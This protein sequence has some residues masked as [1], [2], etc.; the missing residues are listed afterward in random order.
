MSLLNRNN[1]PAEQLHNSVNLNEPEG[2][3]QSMVS[4]DATLLPSAKCGQHRVKILLDTNF[5]GAELKEGADVKLSEYMSGGIG[6]N[7]IIN[8]ISTTAIGSHVPTSVLASANIFNAREEPTHYTDT[9]IKNA[10]GWLSGDIP[11]AETGMQPL[12]NI[13][14]HEYTRKAVLHY[15]PESHL[16][17]RLVQKYGKYAN[18]DD[19]WQGIVPFPGEPYYYVDR[20]HVALNIIAK[21]WE[22][23]GVNLPAER[24]RDDKWIKVASS[25]IDQ[26]VDELQSSVIDK[27]PFTALDKL[28]I[29]FKSSNPNL[30]D[31]DRY[32][33]AVEFMLD[34]SVPELTAEPKTA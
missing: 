3:E 21:N 24:L 4:E 16:E 5:T 6:K 10:E 1:K 34:Y 20:N 11:Q 12:C 33:L 19:L 7:V 17:D 18:S 27:M 23:L 22:Q 15:S 2:L 8:G 13:L 26:V 32:P 9:K 25:V 28:A 29:Q 30:Q 31:A 14:P